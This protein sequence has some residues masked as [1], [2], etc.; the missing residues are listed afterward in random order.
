MDKTELLSRFP[1][2]PRDLPLE[3]FLF[4]MGR[5]ALQSNFSR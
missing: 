1:H 3:N 4:F 2:I 5:P